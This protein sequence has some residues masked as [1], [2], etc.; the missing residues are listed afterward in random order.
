MAARSTASASGQTLVGAANMIVHDWSI[1]RSRRGAA[2]LETAF[3]DLAVELVVGRAD[4]SGKDSL[5]DRS[6]ATWRRTYE[7]NVP[8]VYS[9]CDGYDCKVWF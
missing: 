2:A 9:Y 4:V 6:F 1:H 3:C 7:K 8:F 5:S